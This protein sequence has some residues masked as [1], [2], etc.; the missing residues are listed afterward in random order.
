MN[1]NGNKHEVLSLL[2]SDI[3]AEALAQSRDNA[4]VTHA[5]LDLLL[6]QMGLDPPEKAGEANTALVSIV[7]AE[8]RRFLERI[9]GKRANGRERWQRWRQKQSVSQRATNAQLTVS[10]PLARD[11]A[12]SVSVTDTATPSQDKSCSCVGAAEPPAAHSHSRKEDE[13]PEQTGNEP[14][15]DKPR[16][17]AKDKAR[18]KDAAEVTAYAKSIGYDLDAGRF[19]D[20]YEAQGWK[21]SN[22]RPLADWKAAVRIWQRRDRDRNEATATDTPESRIKDFILP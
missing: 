13:A 4:E 15:R 12:V 5:L 7:D 11:N 8:Q 2:V 9:E 6:P 19:M 3:L 20:F 10:T 14:T 17:R 1:S 21:Q 16:D 22:G 18:P